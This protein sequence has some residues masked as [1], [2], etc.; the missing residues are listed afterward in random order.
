LGIEGVR[1]EACVLHVDDLAGAI[2]RYWSGSPD[3]SGSV[4]VG[5]DACIVAAWTA[6]SD[7]GAVEVGECGYWF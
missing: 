5:A 4:V 1:L 7:G 3:V 2:G 6:A